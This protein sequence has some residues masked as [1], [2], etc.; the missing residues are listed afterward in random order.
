MLQ[1]CRDLVANTRQSYW[2]V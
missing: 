2:I 1:V